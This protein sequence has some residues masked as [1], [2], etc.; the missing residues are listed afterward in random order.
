MDVFNLG[1]LAGQLMANRQSSPKCPAC[2]KPESVKQTCNHCGHEYTEEEMKE[3]DITLKQVL[4]VGG[5]LLLGGWVL[6]TLL[7]WMAEGNTL[8]EVLKG[9]V[10]W[11]K[12]LFGRIA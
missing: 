4:V 10:E 7:Y 6:F 1:L 8:V 5:F 3:V 12:E 2:G 11:V 9:Q